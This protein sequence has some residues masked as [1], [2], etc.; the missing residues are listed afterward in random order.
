MDF[1]MGKKQAWI[2][3]GPYNLGLIHFVRVLIRIPV[4]PN[5]EKM[6]GGRSAKF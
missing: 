4:Q 5:K 6:S 1:A 2:L 3:S